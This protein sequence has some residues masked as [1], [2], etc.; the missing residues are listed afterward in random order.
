MTPR[1]IVATPTG[2]RRARTLYVNGDW[3]I[4]SLDDAESVTHTPTGA[5]VAY[6]RPHQALE[7]SDAVDGLA[8]LE[9]FDL[10][11]LEKNL[12]AVLRVLNTLGPRGER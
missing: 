6:C 9:R 10:Q 2:Y 7:W 5:K 8:T 1:T 12:P 4:V 3:A 11:G